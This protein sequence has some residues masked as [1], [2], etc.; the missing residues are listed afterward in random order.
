MFLSRG[1]KIL[2]LLHRID[3][4]RYKTLFGYYKSYSE[5]ERRIR[6]LKAKIERLGGDTNMMIKVEAREKEGDIL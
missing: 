2:L 6:R 3:E 4:M 5:G 1:D